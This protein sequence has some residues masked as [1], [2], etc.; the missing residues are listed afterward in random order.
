MPGRSWHVL[1]SGDCHPIHDDAEDRADD[2]EGVKVLHDRVSPPRKLDW[3]RS[4][5]VPSTF[6]RACRALA[7]STGL[8]IAT[9]DCSFLMSTLE[10]PDRYNESA[11]QDDGG[12]RGG[13]N[14]HLTS[15]E[16]RPL[17][18]RAIDRQSSEM[19]A[20]HLL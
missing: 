3:K 6:D 4:D 20:L 5:A 18:T 13:R 11:V 15:R 7:S 17:S 8:S 1:S 2:C 10:D 14:I 9:G 16:P 19:D 12:S